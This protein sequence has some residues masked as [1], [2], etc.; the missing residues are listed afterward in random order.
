MSPTDNYIEWTEYLLHTFRKFSRIPCDTLLD[1][2]SGGGHNAFHL[3][4]HYRVT[5]V[6]LS[7]AMLDV[8]RNLNP[9]L[10]HIQGDMRSVRLRRL[11]S[12]VLIDDS[13]SYMLSENDLAE[14]FRTAWEHLEP[15][16]VFIT[17]IEQT[18]EGWVRY[19]TE[20]HTV[21]VAGDLRLSYDEE[22]YDPDPDDST[23]ECLLTYRL[24]APD[25]LR[26]EADLHLLGIFPLDR[27]LRTAE[28]IGFT[29]ILESVSFSNSP[30]GTAMKA[31]ICPKPLTQF[32]KGS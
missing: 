23:Y 15:G 10:E 22:L 2:G 28:E 17:P 32:S 13:I 11:F 3:K 8:S 25:E 27:W 26:V 4:H 6:D 19:K 30:P 9:E 14:A 29:P 21:H 18:K 31:L 1:L 16:G 5:C 7:P 12:L 24:R 20:S